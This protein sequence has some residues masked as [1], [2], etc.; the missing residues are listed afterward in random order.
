[1]IDRQ[2]EIKMV[3][4]INHYWQSQFGRQ[5]NSYH[6]YKSIN[7]TNKSRI[8]D[9]YFYTTWKMYHKG[10]EKY[11]SGVYRYNASTKSFKATKVAGNAKK[12]DAIARAIKLKNQ[13]A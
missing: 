12:Q 1:M 11:L 10:S 4:T 7:D 2:T 6:F 9:R 5:Q 13:K 8:K 3:K